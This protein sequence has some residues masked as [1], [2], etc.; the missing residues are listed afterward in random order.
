MLGPKPGY[1]IMVTN[2]RGPQFT[3]SFPLLIALVVR[4]S[5]KADKAVA[6]LVLGR[7]VTYN[8]RDLRFKSWLNNRVKV[9]ISWVRVPSLALRVEQPP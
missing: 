4:N 6:R 9:E 5:N 7:A 8:L 2:S 1:C 3:F